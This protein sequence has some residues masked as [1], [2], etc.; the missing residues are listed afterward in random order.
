[1]ADAQQ[2]IAQAQQ[3]LTRVLRKLLDYMERRSETERA[4]LGQLM[5]NHL[6]GV[7]QELLRGR[8]M[9][10]AQV[11]SN[12][13]ATA[14][15]GWE[16][17]SADF[18]RSLNR[19]HSMFSDPAVQEAFAAF[20]GQQERLQE[21]ARAET[22]RQQQTPGQILGRSASA[23]YDPGRAAQ[24][25]RDQTRTA[26]PARP[27]PP[28]ANRTPTQPSP[29][30]RPTHQPGQQTP[31]QPAPPQPGPRTGPATGPQP[32][33]AR[34]PQPGPT[35]GP[36]TGPQTGPQPGP[37]QPTPGQAGGQAT[38]RP[39]N[40]GGPGA[41][42]L[43]ARLLGAAGRV[44]VRADP[45]CT[46]A[47]ITIST[48]DQTGPAADAVRGATLES[49]PDGRITASAQVTAN[50]FG[51]NG[52]VFTSGDGASVQF[53][54]GSQFGHASNLN[55]NSMNINGRTLSMQGMSGGSLSIEDGQVFVNGQP[56][57]L[58]PPTAPIEIH[59]VVPEGSSIQCATDSANL[60][61]HG[62]VDVVQ[63]R[64]GSGDVNVEQATS[65]RAETGSGEIGVGTAD[66]V[67]ARSG[68]GDVSV[69]KAVEVDANSGSGNVEVG[70]AQN[71]VGRTGSGNV[72]VDKAVNV[73]ASSGSGNVQVAE[74][75]NVVASSGSG[76]VQVAEGQKVVASSGSGKVSVTR[77]ADVQAQTGSGRIKVENAD[78]VVATSRKG[79]IDIG[80]TKNAA[81][82]SREGQVKI[83][84]LHGTA[85]ARSATGSVDVHAAEGGHVTASS[86]LGPVTVTA[87]DQAIS[88]G[89]TVRPEGPP[90]GVRIPAGAHTET[91]GARSASSGAR[92]FQSAGRSGPSR[93]SGN[94]VS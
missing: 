49:T 38:V 16:G 82:S 22:A 70:E 24:V 74:G 26:P 78:K 51:S 76:N 31:P 62:K 18:F 94:E 32:G 90:G 27:T 1:M 53:G 23:G 8:A 35:T 59:A 87:S 36:R 67:Q 43:D 20:A 13:E 29:P 39:L 88:D 92:D 9:S 68:S 15:A 77:A 81:A 7:R 47:S 21:V 50:T 83:T 86:T 14:Q 85:D 11:S 5:D 79:N 66:R 71:V 91:A 61:T 10:D 17:R 12:L 6:P 80:T 30:S 3:A 48:M 42:R 34:A 58:G 33:A 54:D 93:A 4:A 63:A 57:D 2:V 73:D 75:Q 64:S 52:A 84:D 65:L 28:P 55:I 45:N 41:V 40:A 60:E 44:V 69:G 25:F 72:S 46:Q 19:N 56:V 37:A 89:L